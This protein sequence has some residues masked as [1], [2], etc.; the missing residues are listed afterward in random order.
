MVLEDGRWMEL[1]ENHV[2]MWA[3]VLVVL[4]VWLLLQQR[5]FVQSCCHSVHFSFLI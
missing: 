4:N 1:A 5:L 2:Q 3:S